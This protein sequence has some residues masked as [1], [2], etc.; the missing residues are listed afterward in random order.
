MQRWRHDGSAVVVGAGFLGAA[1]AVDL[2]ATGVPTTVL[3]RSSLPGGTTAALAG[4]RLVRG[5]ARDAT[6]ARRALEGAALVLWCAGS[7]LPDESERD[8]IGSLHDTIEP[9]VSVLDELPSSVRQFVY[10]SSG[11]T[12]YGPQGS[13]PVAETAVPA[14]TT[15]YGIARLAAEQFVARGCSSRGVDSLVL[16]CANVYGP[17]QPGNRSQGLVAAALASIATGAPLRVFGDGATVRDYVYVEDFVSVVAELVGRDLADA[18]FNV[19]SGRGSSVNDVVA[20]AEQV[21]GREVRVEYAPQ[22]PCDTEYAV[23]DT[24][25]LRATV[26]VSPRTLGDGVRATWLDG[27]AGREVVRIA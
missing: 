2:A 16:R 5:D 24:T 4:C 6:A 3:H 20:T 10:L 11:G 9:L 21:T 25:R 1:L 15:A 17:G 7:P 12:I 22:R 26:D 18:T 14:P 27:W 23:L 13:R 19:G 8:P